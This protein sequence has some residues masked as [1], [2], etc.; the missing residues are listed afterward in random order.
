MFY[1][2]NLYVCLSNAEII[3]KPK[4]SCKFMFL[5]YKMFKNGRLYMF[6]FCMKQQADFS[7]FY[8]EHI[9]IVNDS[10]VVRM[11]LQVVV[12]PITV[13]LMAI[14]VSLML[15]ENI[16]ITSITHED[17]YIFIVQVTTVLQNSCKFVS[18]QLCDILVEVRKTD[19]KTGRDQITEF[20]KMTVNYWAIKFYDSCP[21]FVATWANKVQLALPRPKDRIL[22]KSYFGAVLTLE[23]AEALVSLYIK[24]IGSQF[25][26]WLLN[27]WRYNQVQ[28][29]VIHRYLLHF[30]L[31]SVV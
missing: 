4:K 1:F 19:P 25:T 3:T 30:S 18:P 7:S 8:Y 16:Y 17:Y 15:L 13:I 12:S 27:Q 24:Y 11:T 2:L 6:D 14:E 21:R 31:D 28:K 10:R 26:I 9:T 22:I 23:K 5:S 29:L 20:V